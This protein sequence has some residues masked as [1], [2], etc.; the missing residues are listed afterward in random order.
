MNLAGLPGALMYGASV[1]QDIKCRVVGRCAYGAPIDRE[2]G[3]L[4]PRNDAGAEIPLEEDLGK[5][6][7]YLRYNADLRRAGLDMMG[8]KEI[9]EAALG[10]LDSVAA[11]DDLPRVGTWVSD[12]IKPEHF[13]SFITKGGV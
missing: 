11:M 12:Q 8:F 9:D 7:L 6:F 10:Q 4:I 13:G 1:D 2:I 3:D 5:A